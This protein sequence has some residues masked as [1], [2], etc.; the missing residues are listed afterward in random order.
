M[1]NRLQKIYAGTMNF[2]E[3][4]FRI[5]GASVENAVRRTRCYQSTNS[6]ENSP[7]L[8]YDSNNNYYPSNDD[9]NYYPPNNDNN[10]YPSE[11]GNNYLPP[12]QNN[13]FDNYPSNGNNNYR[14][15]S[16]SNSYYPLTA[17]HLYLNY[18]G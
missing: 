16:Y 2:N 4:N 8:D 14:P 3:I 10:Y 13:D 1:T 5:L 18:Y 11:S 17:N 9:S 12:N 7:N 15:P 6:G